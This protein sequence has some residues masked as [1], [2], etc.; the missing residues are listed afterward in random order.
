MVGHHVEWPIME[1]IGER[2]NPLP[3]PPARQP[4]F[5]D[6]P[7]SLE[8]SADSYLFL[9]GFTSLSALTSFSSIGHLLSLCAR[10]FTLFNLT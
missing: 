7:I 2:H 6:S 8:N 3:L 1:D 10:F 4:N 9:T 5:V